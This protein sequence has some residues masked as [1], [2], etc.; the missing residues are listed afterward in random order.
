MWTAQ[1]RNPTMTL[2]QA[3]RESDNPAGPGRRPG[4]LDV[5]VVGHRRAVDE[6]GPASFQRSKVAGSGCSAPAS[7]AASPS[8]SIPASFSSSSSSSAARRP[9]R[10]RLPPLRTG[11][12]STSSFSSDSATDSLRHPAPPGRRRAFLRRLRPLPPRPFAYISSRPTE[13]CRLRRSSYPASCRDRRPTLR[14]LI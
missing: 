4:L 7:S 6:A 3:R 10:R 13:S 8:P 14:P 1:I 5:L 2:G 9:L 12:A 11:S